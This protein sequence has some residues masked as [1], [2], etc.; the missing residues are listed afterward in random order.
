MCIARLEKRNE[1]LL[2]T[3]FNSKQRGALGRAVE[4][5]LDFRPLGLGFET[6]CIHVWC[7]F[8]LRL[9]ALRPVHR[10]I[11]RAWVLKSDVK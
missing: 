6:R 5:I 3:L 2:E 7:P 4:H 8:I 11:I 10:Y 9:I 1:E